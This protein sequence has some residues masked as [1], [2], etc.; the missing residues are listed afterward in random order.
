MFPTFC[1]TTFC[2]IL[3]NLTV[4]LPQSRDR[5]CYVILASPPLWLHKHT[6]LRALT[7]LWHQPRLA[8][9]TRAWSWRLCGIKPAIATD[10]A[11]LHN[12]NSKDALVGTMTAY[13]GVEVWFH[14]LITSELNGYQRL[15]SRCALFTPEKKIPLYPVSMRLDGPKSRSERCLASAGYRN[16]ILR[17]P[18]S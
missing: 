3:T 13:V 7:D 14:T 12:V 18:R 8:D 1:M 17:S 11:V 10:K 5:S 15:T 6:D 9:I 16:W 4:L 2:A